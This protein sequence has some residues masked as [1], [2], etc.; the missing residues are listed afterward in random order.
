MRYCVYND[1]P[2]FTISKIKPWRTVN[3]NDFKQALEIIKDNLWVYD[4]DD[5]YSY[6][7]NVGLKNDDQ[8]KFYQIEHKI[9]V[10]RN[11]LL[12]FWVDNFFI[13][14]EID[15]PQWFNLD[16]DYIEEE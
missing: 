13:I 15:K 3:A 6:T 12:E 14:K 1:V 7:Y 8:Y 16:G 9:Y 10:T 5:G 11:I 4:C 2:D